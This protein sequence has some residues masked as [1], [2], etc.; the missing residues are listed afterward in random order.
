MY[1]FQYFYMWEFLIIGLSLFFDWY[2]ISG[3]LCQVWL[4]SVSP[5]LYSHSSPD[6][7]DRAYRAYHSYTQAEEYKLCQER[8][9]A[10]HIHIET[11]EVKGR[12][13][14][15]GPR[16]SPTRQWQGICW[17]NRNGRNVVT[18]IMGRGWAIHPT[19]LAQCKHAHTMLLP[20][21][22]HWCMTGH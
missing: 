13:L 17:L 18:C 16:E 19:T 14:A 12:V 9:L 11:D 21:Y 8:E 22:T 7:P 10:E 2:P 20:K 5:L 3:C 15:R 4:H 1:H 6:V